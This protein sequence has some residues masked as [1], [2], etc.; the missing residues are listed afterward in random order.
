[1]KEKVLNIF[2]RNGNKKLDPIKIVKFLS[3]DYDVKDVK[4][5]MD[6]I[7]ELELLYNKEFSLVA[8]W[9]YEKSVFLNDI[10]TPDYCT[11][12]F[13]DGY[14]ITLTA[15]N[16][17]VNPSNVSVG[18]GGSAKFKVMNLNIVFTYLAH[19][20]L[21]CFMEI[22]IITQNQDI[23]KLVKLKSL[24]LQVVILLLIKQHTI[25]LMMVPVSYNIVV[26]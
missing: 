17:T 24:I 2:K 19:T 11:I 13:T 22:R 5:V 12:D 9:N 25:I 23:Y 26:P 7:Y 8:E 21:L 18:Y 15:T 3:K 4:E 20:V 14:I 16:E 6:I 10:K 1:M